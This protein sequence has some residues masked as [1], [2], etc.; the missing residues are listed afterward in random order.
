LARNDQNDF[1][2]AK[3]AGKDLPAPSRSSNSPEGL[4]LL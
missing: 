3:N 2:Q 1:S 4:A